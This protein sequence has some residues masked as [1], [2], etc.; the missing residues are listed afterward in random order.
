M[1]FH[2]GGRILNIPSEEDTFGRKKIFESVRNEVIAAGGKQ[3]WSNFMI[4][5]VLS[6]LK[7][8]RKF[9]DSSLQIPDTEI[10]YQIPL[11]TSPFQFCSIIDIHTYIEV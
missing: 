5:E 2:A 11:A 10:R 3:E 9:Y 7:M 8:C 4:Q 1:A 6:E